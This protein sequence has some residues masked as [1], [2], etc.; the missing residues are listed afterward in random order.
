MH[1]FSSA[2]P[3][4][5]VVDGSEAIIVEISTRDPV[6]PSLSLSVADWLKKNR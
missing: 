2:A 6:V 1:P 4:L 5:P 3:P